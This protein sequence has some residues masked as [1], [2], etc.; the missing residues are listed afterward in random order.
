MLRELSLAF[1]V[2]WLV[3][4]LACALG[5]FTAAALGGSGARAVLREA[6]LASAAMLGVAAAAAL[7][8][9]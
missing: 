2:F 7:V 1:A 9:A 4:A 8:S 3:V 6:T 5:W